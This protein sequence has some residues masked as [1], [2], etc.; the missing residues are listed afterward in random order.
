MKKNKQTGQDEG[1]KE[2]EVKGRENVT[3]KSRYEGKGK[4]DMQRKT[5]RQQRHCS[6]NFIFF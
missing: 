4:K 1:N 2:I 6:P 3:E 5:R